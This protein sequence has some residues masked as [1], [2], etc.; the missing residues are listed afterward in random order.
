MIKN[1]K[2]SSTYEE[3]NEMQSCN[4]YDYFV[5]EL[6]KR[7]NTK[8]LSE[9]MDYIDNNIRKF[10]GWNTHEVSFYEVMTTAHD[11]CLDLNIMP[12]K[13]NKMMIIE[14]M[15]DLCDIHQKNLEYCDTRRHDDDDF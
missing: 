14:H 12:S 5:V 10:L 8:R 2:K 1:V 3:C 9:C 4:A 6:W 13:E 15:F 11:I 7:S